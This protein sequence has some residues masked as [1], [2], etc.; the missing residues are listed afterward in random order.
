[1]I[2]DLQPYPFKNMEH[3][4][5][6]KDLNSLIKRCD[7]VADEAA[8]VQ[9]YN[10]G[11]GTFTGFWS[12]KVKQIRR[13]Y[14]NISELLDEKEY[15]ESNSSYERGVEDIMRDRTIQSHLKDA[16][17]LLK[18]MNEEQKKNKKNVRRVVFVFSFIIYQF[19]NFFPFLVFPFCTLYTLPFCFL[20][21]EIQT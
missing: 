3:A 12:E 19:I 7:A 11:K 20:I 14:T 18:A 17:D 13:W 1:M 6:L 8:R 5:Y 2:T 4:K 15:L 10:N 21:R 9:T 16:M